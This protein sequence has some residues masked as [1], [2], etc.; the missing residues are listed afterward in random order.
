M[1]LDVE[2]LEFPPPELPPLDEPPE[3]LPP[4]LF[5][6]LPLSGG[7][8]SGFDN[9]FSTMYSKLFGSVTST[10]LFIVAFL[11]LVVFCANPSFNITF[12]PLSC[13]S[14]LTIE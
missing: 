2:S 14:L 5:P 12:E 4:P 9:S 6:P 8:S 10:Y 11:P 13:V 7:N 1:T 3:L